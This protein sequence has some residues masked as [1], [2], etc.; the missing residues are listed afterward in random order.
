MGGGGIGGAVDL[1]SVAPWL[2]GILDSYP[3]LGSGMHK[4]I[5]II[6]GVVFFSYLLYPCFSLAGIPAHFIP[7]YDTTPVVFLALFNHFLFPS[8]GQMPGG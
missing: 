8:L 6:G 2:S 5:F 3:F 7:T 4:G 1:S